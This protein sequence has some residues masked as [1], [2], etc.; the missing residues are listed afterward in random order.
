MTQ[1][2]HCSYSN[3]QKLQKQKQGS[4]GHN[5]YILKKKRGENKR[6]FS[7][8]PHIC[9]L[10]SSCLC[11]KYLVQSSELNSQIGCGSQELTGCWIEDTKILICGAQP[12]RKRSKTQQESPSGLGSPN[13]ITCTMNGR[14]RQKTFPPESLI[15]EFIASTGLTWNEKTV[16]Y[17]E[18]SK[19]I[20]EKKGEIVK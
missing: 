2:N 1:P 11:I 13:I 4:S 7:A 10:E 6:Q 16:H 3:K 12:S 14:K 20:E 17:L 15:C 9:T 19:E 18:F 5:T 8:Q